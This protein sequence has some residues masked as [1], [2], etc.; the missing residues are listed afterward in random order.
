MGL[1]LG[2]GGLRG[3]S[4]FCGGGVIGVGDGGCC[5]CR[6]SWRLVLRRRRRGVWVVVVGGWRCVR[7][8]SCRRRR[9]E[10]RIGRRLWGRI[11][12]M[13]CFGFLR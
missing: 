10:G 13:G 12:W 6:L 8:I 1:D 2:C 7:G 4:G 5:C 9:G 11:V 3:G